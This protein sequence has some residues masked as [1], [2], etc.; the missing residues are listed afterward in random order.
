MARLLPPE[1]DIGV[2]RAPIRSS[3]VLVG[4][5]L[6]ILLAVGLLDRIGA[7]PGFAPFA[8]VGTA[9]ALFVL[10]ALYSHSRRATDFYV[11]DRKA[12]AKI[13]GLAGAGALAGLLAVGLAGGAYDTP[14]SFLLSALGLAAGFLVLGFVIAP[15]LRAFGGYT[16][17]DFIG[18]R[19]GGMPARLAWAGIT[20]TVSFLL[21]IAAL[22][23][24]APLVAAVFGVAPTTALYASAALGAMATLPGGMRSLSWTQAIQYMVI[25]IACLVPAAFFAF[26]GPTAQ[27]AIAAQ[28]ATL[29]T[30]SLPAWKDAA[31]AGWALPILLS[32]LGT[33]SLPPLSARTLTAPS[34]REAVTSMLWA[35]LFSI[36]L[37]LAG[38]VLF[39]LLADSAAAE[40]AEALGGGQV[41]LATLFALLPPVF[42]GLLLAGT[43]AALL[44]LGQAA[45]FSAA[46]ALSHD[47]WDEIIDRSGPEGRRIMIA[48]LIIAGLAAGAVALAAHWPIDAASLVVWALAMAAGGTFMPLALGLWWRRCNEIGAIGGMVAGFGFSALVFLLQAN[49]I[50]DAVVTSGWADVSAPTAAAVGLAMSFAVTVGLSLVTPAPEKDAQSL[51]SGSDEGRRLPVRERPA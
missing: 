4:I 24:A 12:S 22:K 34:G 27:D 15:G 19:F 48:R 35:V 16:A 13:S 33:A 36:M 29:V 51:A 45:L 39:E 37:V 14:S 43:L 2:L 17:G 28:F 41:Q 32:V 5:F 42:A 7:A 21:F 20:F 47:V 49:L 25:A 40:A 1:R 11:A 46:T 18:A 10:A 3:I 9:F 23:I 38:F 8:I 50:P 31:T 44:A 30:D 26:G 6:A